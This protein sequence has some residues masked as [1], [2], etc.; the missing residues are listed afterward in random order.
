VKKSEGKLVLARD[1]SP[2]SRKP[3]TK[4][5]IDEE[6]KAALRAHL[7]SEDGQRCL[8]G[9]AKLTAEWAAKS[10]PSQVRLARW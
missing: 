1:K 8:D 4:F 7:D 9:F 3:P 2:P 6:S 5:N 10:Y